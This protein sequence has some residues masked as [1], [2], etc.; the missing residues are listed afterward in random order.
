MAT[1]N[2]EIALRRIEETVVQMASFVEE[3]IARAL[4]AMTYADDRL[5]DEVIATDRIVDDLRGQVRQYVLQAIE[6]WA[7]MGPSLRMIIAYQFIG[8]QLE[9]I[10]DYA[11]HVARGAR[12]S[13]RTMPLQIAGRMSE[14]ARL[15]RQQVRDG[16]RALAAE[17]V[18]LARQVCLADNP[19][20][21]CYRDLLTML[22]SFM[23]SDPDKVAEATMMLF[24]LRDLE[25]I[26]DRMANIC[27][28]IIFIRTGIHEDLN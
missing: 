21:D 27:E 1:E 25:R 8:E 15:V 5:A 23:Q 22:Q 12:V 2:I 3:L 10:G 9:R 6:R 17:D 16:V 20:D 19:I 18:D 24:A 26:G 7:P 14:M 28:D 4:H 11:V 13:Y